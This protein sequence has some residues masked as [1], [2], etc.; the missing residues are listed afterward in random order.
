MKEHRLSVLAKAWGLGPSSR[1]GAGSFG[2]TNGSNDL[3]LH[4]QLV[5]ETGGEV[6]DATL[7]ITSHVG[8]LADLVEHVPTSE[9]EDTN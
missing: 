2:L 3:S 1:A 4:A 6:A 8:H 9:H 7:S 5:L